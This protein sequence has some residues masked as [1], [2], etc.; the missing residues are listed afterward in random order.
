MCLRLSGQ[1]SRKDAA[2]TYFHRQR[3]SVGID[4]KQLEHAV[5]VLN[6]LYEIDVNRKPATYIKLFRVWQNELSDVLTTQE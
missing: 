6:L 5:K 4:S 2:L 1:S 3:W